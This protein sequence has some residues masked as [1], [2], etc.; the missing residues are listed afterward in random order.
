MSYH[1]AQN[2]VHLRG[3]TLVKEF[4]VIDRPTKLKE[5]VISIWKYVVA[6]ESQLPQRYF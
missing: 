6:N 5:K 4:P 2:G 3:P 1:V